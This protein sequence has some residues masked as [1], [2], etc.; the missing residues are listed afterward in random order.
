[1]IRRKIA[2]QDF[3]L[4]NQRLLHNEIR[5]EFISNYSSMDQLSPR[6]H[7][8]SDAPRSELARHQLVVERL[9]QPGSE[10]PMDRHGYADQRVTQLVL[11]WHNFGFKAIRAENEIQILLRFE[12]CGEIPAPGDS[13]RGFPTGFKAAW[14]ATNPVDVLNL[15]GRVRP[16]D[17]RRGFPTGFKAAWITTNPV[18]VLNLV[19]RVRPPAFKARISHRIQSDMDCNESGGR[20]ESCG[21][22]A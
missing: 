1:M 15:V 2:P 3:K 12:S 9:V 14:I 13:Q 18:D 7:L 19:G 16:W 10:F 20:F 17:S 6:F 4:G 22:S 11:D 21:S 8:M 5:L